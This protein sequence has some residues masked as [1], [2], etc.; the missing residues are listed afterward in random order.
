MKRLA[1]FCLFL[2]FSIAQAG[3]GDLQYVAINPDE[4]LTKNNLIS[5]GSFDRDGANRIATFKIGDK[6]IK[7]ALVYRQA[8]NKNPDG[9]AID[10]TGEGNFKSAAVIPFKPLPGG[11]DFETGPSTLKMPREGKSCSVYALA[12][13]FGG[14]SESVELILGMGGQGQCTFGEKTYKIRLIDTSQNLKLG[15]A[16]SKSGQSGSSEAKTMSAHSGIVFGDTIIVQV[17]SKLVKGYCGQPI[18]VDGKWY[19]VTLDDAGAKVSAEAASVEG[20]FIQIPHNNWSAVLVGQKYVLD[21]V[22]G[23]DKVPVPSDNYKIVS[24]TEREGKAYFTC[25]GGDHFNGGEAPACDVAAEKTLELA[26]GSPLM[27][28]PVIQQNSKEVNFNALIQDSSGMRVSKIVLASGT[29]PPPPDIVVKDEKSNVVHTA[30][31]EY[32]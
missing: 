24:Y 8:G 18:N 16:P 17:G 6:T 7:A 2:S 31:L 27:G 29:R 14:K 15:D 5:T 32:G 26:V 9:V 12:R 28:V 3:T 20:G 22:G 19:N 25:V 23:K 4:G 13:Y 21:V 11:S 1:A 10:L 30:K